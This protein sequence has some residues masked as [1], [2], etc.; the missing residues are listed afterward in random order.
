MGL[1][2]AAVVVAGAA[3]WT[4]GELA[5]D[6][7]PGRATG[8][9][10]V[11]WERSRAATFVA[12]GTWEREASDGRRLT[13]EAY[14]A[15]RPPE[16]VQRE[17]GA[18][19]GRVDDRILLCPATPGGAT[20][21]CRLGAPTGAGYRAAVEAE[22]E[23]LEALVRGDEPLYSVEAGEGGGCFV[24]SQQRPDP[25]APYGRRATMCFDPATGAPTRREVH[26]AEGVTETVVYDDLGTEVTDADLEL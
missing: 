12:R 18:V 9:L 19:Q 25:R 8:E 4:A 16:R 15:Q 24:L 10:L 23:A 5:D 13:S 2:A 14:L 3:L 17:L 21:Q 20:E 26:F 11:A 1:V 6:E 22:L 7:P